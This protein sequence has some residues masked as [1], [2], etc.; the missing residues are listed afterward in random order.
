MNVLS[1]QECTSY[2]VLQKPKRLRGL[3]SRAPGSRGQRD[4]VTSPPRF[5]RSRHRY[6]LMGTRASSCR[7]RCLLPRTPGGAGAR[8]RTRNAGK[9]RCSRTV[10][11]TRK[12]LTPKTNVKVF[13][14]C[15]TPDEQWNMKS[16]AFPAT[17][18]L[19]DVVLPCR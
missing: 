8:A 16:C 5:T 13:L 18:V 17:L 11:E 4:G 14:G 2:M 10:G 19:P 7:P 15:W 9:D 12:K 1:S 3:F 6:R